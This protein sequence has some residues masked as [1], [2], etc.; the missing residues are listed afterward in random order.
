MLPARQPPASRNADRALQSPPQYTRLSTRP[1]AP[2]MPR[3]SSKTKK[4]DGSI[5]WEQVAPAKA[6]AHRVCL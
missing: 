6:L 1:A 5:I 3:G 2:S 4:G